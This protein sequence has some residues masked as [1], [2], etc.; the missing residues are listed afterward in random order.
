[1]HNISYRSNQKISSR[2][3]RVVDPDGVNLGILEL[4]KALS[5]A[6]NYGL[7][8]VE[9]SP[10]SQPPVCRIIS[11]SKLKY[12]AQIKTKES[13]KGS[14]KNEVKEIKMRPVIEEHDYKTKLT[15]A[16]K[17]ISNGN[18]IR[19]TIL[20]KGREATHPEQANKIYER[21]LG[22]VKDIATQK[23]SISKFGKDIIFTLEPN[24]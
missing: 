15:W 23:G 5:L 19:V 20:I 10:E 4:E 21:F 14:T 3:V 13:K 17:F 7:D 22:D 1:M 12:Q 9:I 24:K 2:N 11:L 16:R 6:E 8:L 18:T